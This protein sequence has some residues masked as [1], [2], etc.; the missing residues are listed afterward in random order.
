MTFS[1]GKGD[2]WEVYYVSSAGYR[3][4]LPKRRRVGGYFEQ[5][6]EAAKAYSAECRKALLEEIAEAEEEEAEE[7]KA[8]AAGGGVVGDV[9]HAVAES[10]EDDDG[11]SD[12]GGAGIGTYEVEA[13]LA[14]R[15]AKAKGKEERTEYHVKWKGCEGRP[16]IHAPRPCLNRLVPRRGQPWLALVCPGLPCLTVSAPEPWQVCRHDVGAVQACAKL[17]RLPAVRGAQ[18]DRAAHRR[19]AGAIA[20]QGGRAAHWQMPRVPGQA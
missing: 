6:E 17:R 18:R 1:V 8:R 9:F 20:A 4:R 13:I 10:D 15:K 7:V 19:R 12:G 3:G 5:V 14:E 16:H 11:E 2:K